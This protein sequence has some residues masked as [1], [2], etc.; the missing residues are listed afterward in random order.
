[1]IAVRRFVVL[2][3]VT[4]CAIGAAAL[5]AVGAAIAESWFDRKVDD[6]TSGSGLAAGFDDD[7]LR[8]DRRAGVAEAVAVQQAST[9]FV[10][11]ITGSAYD[12]DEVRQRVLDALFVKPL[13]PLAPFAPPFGTSPRPS[14]SR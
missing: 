1:M 5:A 8:D 13:A 12:T 10:I 2:A 4:G 7:Q 14:S 9:P 11:E 6:A 3:A